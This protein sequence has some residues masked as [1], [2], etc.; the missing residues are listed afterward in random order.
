[1]TQTPPEVPP[2][3]QATPPGDEPIEPASPEDTRP[4]PPPENQG[5][6]RFAVFSPELGNFVS[7]VMDKKAASS[8]AKDMKADKDAITHGHKLEVREV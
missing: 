4:A 1:M 2:N 5:S 8:A 7:G 3:Q 6:G